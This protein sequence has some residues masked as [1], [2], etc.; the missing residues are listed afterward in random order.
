MDFVRGI[1]SKGISVT[2]HIRHLYCKSSGSSKCLPMMQYVES[3]QGMCICWWDR[4]REE[5]GRKEDE[6]QQKQ[7]AKEQRL[8]TFTKLLWVCNILHQFL[9]AM[10]MSF[11]PSQKNTGTWADARHKIRTVNIAT[12]TFSCPRSSSIS[13][14]ADLMSSFSSSTLCPALCCADSADSWAESAVS[15]ADSFKESSGRSLWSSV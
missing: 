6:S 15:L 14:V 10:K 8:P 11:V 9:H 2:F 3:M 13:P 12:S 5:F 1:K 4:H 7:L